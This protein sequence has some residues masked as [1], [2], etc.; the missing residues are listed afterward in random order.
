MRVGIGYDV[1]RFTIGR[2]LILGG[3]EVPHK[4]GL[5]AY[6]DGDVL[7]HAIMDAILGAAGLGD[8][9]QHFP[10]D[11]P[12][13]HDASSLTLLER[14]ADLAWQQGFRVANVDVTVLAE[15]P[16]IGPHVGQ[17]KAN[18]AR[19][20]R[21]DGSCVNVKATTNE[22]LGFVGRGEGISAYAVA[23]LE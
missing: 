5:E 22:G 10:P 3:V 1:H 13:Y 7:L 4:M 12:Q 16:R 14:V 23:L 17:M 21:I 9:G 19:A 15:F 11:D 8:I 18:I 20:I 6:S 2:K